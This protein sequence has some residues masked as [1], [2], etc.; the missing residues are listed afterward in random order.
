MTPINGG[1]QMFAIAIFVVG[2]VIYAS[3]FANVTS[4]LGKF[5]EKDRR[6]KEHL[7]AVEEFFKV[8]NTIPH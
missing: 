3:I 4:L 5:D 6:L 8:H 2:A 1:E 7:T